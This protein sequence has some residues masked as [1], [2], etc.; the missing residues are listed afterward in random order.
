MAQTK[1]GRQVW[2]ARVGPK[3]VLVPAQAISPAVE[4]ESSFEFIMVDHDARGRAHVVAPLDTGPSCH[5]P[6]ITGGRLRQCVYDFV[7][8]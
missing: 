4:D 8:R 7:E 3:G 6:S 2:A 5:G 1:Y